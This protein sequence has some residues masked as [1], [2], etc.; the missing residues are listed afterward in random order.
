MVDSKPKRTEDEI[1]QLLG[2]PSAAIRRISDELVQLGWALSEGDE[3]VRRAYYA[4]L[5]EALAKGWTP[6][7][8]DGQQEVM[9]GTELSNELYDKYE[10][11]QAQLAK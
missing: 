3:S 5:D 2:Y 1:A 11:Y 4:K 8:L 10:T 9:L 7:M 6:F